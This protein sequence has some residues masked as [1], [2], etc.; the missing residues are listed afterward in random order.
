MP[1]THSLSFHAFYIVGIVDKWESMTMD[2]NKGGIESIAWC[3]YTVS[4]K[5]SMMTGRG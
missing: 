2:V 4:C 3:R 5:T 1:G